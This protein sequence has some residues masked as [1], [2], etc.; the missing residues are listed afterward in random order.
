MAVTW[1]EVDELTHYYKPED[2]EYLVRVVTLIDK[3][4]QRPVTATAPSK[5]IEAHVTISQM[6]LASAWSED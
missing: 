4:T 1:T 2:H 6:S 5:D 3:R